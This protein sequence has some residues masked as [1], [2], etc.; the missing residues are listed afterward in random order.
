MS[1]MLDSGSFTSYAVLNRI[2]F[3]V[4]TWCEC[5]KWSAKTVYNFH[6]IKRTLSR[7]RNI[8]TFRCEA[9]GRTSKQWPRNDYS[10]FIFTGWQNN[11]S[12]TSYKG[13]ET[14]TFSS[15]ENA[16]H[17]HHYHIDQYFTHQFVKGS[18]AMLLVMQSVY[19][20]FHFNHLAII[21][22]SMFLLAFPVSHYSEESCGL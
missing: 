16:S 5:L 11:E 15:V 6:R 7:N 21:R 22:P 12:N 2:F 17:N 8:F 1:L 9:D 14:V 3:K 4:S 13:K 10:I 18:S 20:T 19:C